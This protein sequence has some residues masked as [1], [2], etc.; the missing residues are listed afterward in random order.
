MDNI[1]WSPALLHLAHAALFVAA[2][3][4][5]PWADWTVFAGLT[6]AVGVAHLGAA[7]ALAARQRF[8]AAAWRLSAGASLAWLLWLGWSIARAATY[9]ASLYG[10]LGQGVAAVLAAVFGLAVLVT[11]PLAAWGIGATG[12]VRRPRG[13][14]AVLAVLAGLGAGQWAIDARAIEGVELPVPAG[15]LATAVASAGSDADAG[16]SL[17]TSSPAE[18]AQAPGP[19]HVTLV[20]TFT[21]GDAPRTRCLQAPDGPLALAALRSTLAAEGSAGPVKVDVLV[22]AAPIEPVAELIDGLLVRS[23][24]DGVCLGGRCLMPWQLVALDQFTTHTPLSFIEDLRFG[25][26]AASLRSL[27][28]DEQGT[29]FEGL[30]RVATRSLLLGA[31]GEARA[32]DRARQAGRALDQASLRAA[33]A[34]AEAWMLGAQQRKSGRFRSTLDPYRGRASNRGFSVRR[35]AGATIAA[36]ELGSR[37]AEIRDLAVRSL[38]WIAR[39]ERS[40]PGAGIISSS[41]RAR[42]TD[43][44][45]SAMALVTF[46]ACRDRV[47]PRHDALIGRLGRLLLAM[48]RPDGGFHHRVDREQGAPAE[49]PTLLYANGQIVLALVLLEG[50]VVEHPGAVDLP[51]DELRATVDRAMDYIA[52]PFW[53]H[54]ARDFFFIEENWHCLA[55]RAALPHHRHDGYERFCLDYLA[56][57]ER[58]ILGPEDDVEPAFYG[59]MGFGNVLPPH[60]TPSAGFGETLAAGMAI[61]AAR[62]EDTARE[63]ALIRRVLALLVRRQWLADDCWACTKPDQVI[64]GWSESMASPLIRV[65]YIQHAWSALT[66]GGR[67]AGLLPGEG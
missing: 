20:A 62:G 3:V 60:N 51:G 28:G 26:S 22:R 11:V 50:L 19:D 48:Q 7:A 15:D 2:A 32:L 61:K 53:D 6:A 33:I 4:V 59:G 47:G 63:A 54:P 66:H 27:L 42:V 37:E 55:A 52:G 24:R 10:G 25:V 9:L 13:A 34:A 57:Q 29:G 64:G 58:L 16:S 67:A 38:D 21:A 46:L 23:G 17:M 14:A 36:C 18:C 1:R 12:G 35:Q 65:D 31:S 41:Q 5:L 45:A 44:A 43:T 39:Q 8:A 40:F 56:F 30:V 49:G